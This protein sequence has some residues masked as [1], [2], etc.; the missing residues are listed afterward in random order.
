MKAERYPEHY[1]RWLTIRA[2]CKEMLMSWSLRLRNIHTKPPAIARFSM[3]LLHHQC[4]YSI[5]NILSHLRL[6][7][8][9]NTTKR[10][11]EAATAIPISVRLNWM[12]HQS[13]AMVGADNMSYITYNAQVRVCKGVISRYLL[14]FV[15]FYYFDLRKYTWIDTVN[16]WQ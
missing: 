13:I 16:L 4:P 11:Y 9:I 15:V 2:T 3:L 7:L 10:L 14:I 6:A 8:S 1:Q 12:D 5:W